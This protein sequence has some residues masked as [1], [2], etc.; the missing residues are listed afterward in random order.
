M[1]KSIDGLQA[2][3]CVPVIDSLPLD[4]PY[5]TLSHCWGRTPFLTLTERNIEL[6]RESIP[7]SN[8]TKTFQDALLV[9]TE[10]GFRYIWIDSLCIIQDQQSQQD[11]KSEAANMADVYSNSVC[12]ILA[13]AAE[14]G[15]DGMLADRDG[16][17]A[18]P[19]WIT[20]E[21]KENGK[22]HHKPYLIWDQYGYFWPLREGPLATRGWCMQETLLVSTYLQP[23]LYEIHLFIHICSRPDYYTLALICSIGNVMTYSL[24]KSGRMEFQA[25]FSGEE[26][27]QNPWLEALSPFTSLECRKSK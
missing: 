3:L 12:T 26:A 24:Q 7:I 10:I 9:T 18:I 6:F 27:R 15:S 20:P 16:R 1:C 4:T 23:A 13:A 17:T 14:S 25:L 21:G 8:L 5:L 22:G 11:W 19:P 2:S